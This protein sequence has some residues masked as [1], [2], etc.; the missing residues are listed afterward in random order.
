MLAL[1]ALVALVVPAAPAAAGPA[2]CD[3]SVESPAE[4]FVVDDC[5]RVVILRG[6]NVESSSKGGSQAD[7]HLPRLPLALQAELD[8]WGWNTVRF[9]VFWGAI[10]PQPGVYDEAYLD[11]VG[12]WLDWYADHD[13]HVVL[14]LHQDLYAWQVGGN[15]APDWAVDTDGH[16]FEGV[17][18]PWWLSAT[19]PATQAA[20]QNFWD[21]SRGHPEFQDGF[22]GALRHLAERFGDHPAVVGY[23]VWN[24]PVFANGDLAAT[25]AVIDD[26]AA[27]T[28]RN[29]RLTRFMQRGIDAVR[30]VDPDNWVAVEPTSL[31]NAFP[32]AGDL[33][34]GELDDPRPGPS[35]L[36]Y[37][38]HL[39]EPSAHEGTGYPTEST[40]V[41]SWERF[42]TGESAAL[43]ASLWFGEWGGTSAQPRFGDYIDEVAAM[44]DRAMAGW[45]W[46]SWDPSTSAEG[47]SPIQTDGRVTTNGRRLQRVQPR[48]VAGTPT[49]FWWLPAER[50]FALQWEE[51]AGAQGP[52]ELALPA[53]SYP[54]GF[55]VLVDG[56]VLAVV[57]DATQPAAAPESEGDA[58]SWR[59]D[60]ERSRL[61][62]DP[63]RT[64]ATHEACVV[65]LT[66]APDCPEQPTAPTPAPPAVPTPASPAFTG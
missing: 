13:I 27:G 28:F 7:D 34:A 14:D 44:S 40:Y 33:V 63:D 54:A 16:T 55:Q 4:R 12:A 48:A 51:R 9:L 24:E 19:D 45:A 41:G 20:Y 66:A 56:V 65:P 1:V 49:G 50:A 47:W 31:L 29:Q 60:P 2:P 64:A 15:G 61:E 22:F 42:R 39:Y 35:R 58:G 21:R 53:A 30:S 25:L 17:D 26:A 59:W 6:V 43:G 37:A 3:G 36:L 52:T 38:P 57:A 11:R 46:W 32:Y 10:E 18:G 62:I 23:D 5:G 8:Q